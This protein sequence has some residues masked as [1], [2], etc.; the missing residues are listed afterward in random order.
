M[1]KWNIFYN[2]DVGPND[3]SFWEWWEVMDAETEYSGEETRCFKCD[4]EADAEWL[5]EILNKGDL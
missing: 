2:N 4:T 5:A 3:E 1:N